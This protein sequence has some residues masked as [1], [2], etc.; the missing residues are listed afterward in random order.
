MKKDK[1]LKIEDNTKEFIAEFKATVEAAASSGTYGTFLGYDEKHTK[2]CYKLS[3]VFDRGSYKFRFVTVPNVLFCENFVDLEYEINGET[4]SIYDIFNLFD[5][6]D[7]EQY[8][9][10]DVSTKAEIESSMKMLFD[11]VA[12]YDF[13][14]KKAAQSEY[15]DKLKQNRDSDLKSGFK[16]KTDEEIENDIEEFTEVFGIAPSHPMFS[17]ASDATDSEKLL[18]SLEKADKKGKIETIYEKRLLEYLRNGNK[19]VNQGKENRK[20]FDKAYTKGSFLSDFIC[21]VC[22]AV[23]AV[24]L[25]LVLRSIVYSGADLPTYSLAV[26]D[27]KT[28]FSKEGVF[29]A[30][31]SLIMFACAFSKL[32]GKKVLAKI[33]P[34]DEKAIQRYETENGGSY[35][36]KRKKSENI[37]IIVIFIVLALCGSMFSATSL[38]GFYDDGAKFSTTDSPLPEKVSYDDM[39]IY[40]VEYP[41]DEEGEKYEN[42]YA[43]SDGKGGYYELGEL[44][45]GGELEKRILSIAEKYNK[46]IETVKTAYEITK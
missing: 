21:I 6:N 24:L 12:K 5:V 35:G 34:D 9:F 41:D 32:F 22:G 13:D 46:Q 29:G 28:H 15:F 36:K 40:S 4:F 23:F 27:L 2:S 38:V 44:T 16:N 37:I 26:T 19:F 31:F 18:K 43:I 33:M 8:Y 25:A 45:P 1:K 30:A 14:V 17:A 11:A 39:Q 3:A 42:A 20:A 10:Y 7:F